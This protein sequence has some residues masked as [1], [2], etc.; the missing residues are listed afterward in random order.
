VKD[1]IRQVKTQQDQLYFQQEEIQNVQKQLISWQDQIFQKQDQ[2]R[3]TLALDSS[4]FHRPLQLYHGQ[5]CQGDV[6][7]SSM[8]TVVTT[9]PD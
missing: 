7:P 8:P 4:S 1:S 3:G 6:N 2:I 5:Q 9:Q